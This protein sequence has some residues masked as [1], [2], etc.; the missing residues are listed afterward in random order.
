MNA[1]KHVVLAGVLASLLGCPAGDEGKQPQGGSSGGGEPAGGTSGGGAAEPGVFTKSMQEWAKTNLGALPDVAESASN[2]LSQEKVDLGR[3]LY[4]DTRFS[5]NHD[6]S[7]NTCHELTRYGIDVRDDN[8]VSMGHKN[9]KGTRNAPTVFNA[10][11]HTSQFWD[12]R[13]PDVEHQALGPLINPVEHAMVDHGA[14]IGI[15]NTIPGYAELFQAAFPDDEQPVTI[16]NFGKAVGAF[17]RM[18]VTPSPFDAFVNGDFSALTEEQIEGI[19][20]YKDHGCITC[21]AGPS[22]GGNMKQKLGLKAPYKVDGK[23]HPDNGTEFKVP[24][25]R[26]VAETAPYLHDGSVK[27]LTTVVKG[28]AEYQ[29]GMSLS[30][31][32]A[33]KLVAFLQSLTGT[34]DEE[35]VKKPELPE[36]GPD[37]PQPDPK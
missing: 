23:V 3:I 7:C 24:G 2:P 18:L 35:F 17:E 11:F 15:V 26:N 20:V 31:D 25:L 27:D 36:S 33:A 6:V 4:Y 1:L 12:G 28:M 10:A 16:E 32:D 13:E 8:A 37:T 22:L 19:G 21:H 14:V 30:D 29:A 9:Q 5:P 34:V